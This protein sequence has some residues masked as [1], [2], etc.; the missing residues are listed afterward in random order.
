[1]S[2][3]PIN[4]VF[5]F[6][7]NHSCFIL[8]E[9]GDFN[10]ENCFSYIFTCPLKIIQCFKLQEVK[11]CLAQ[12]QSALNQG[13]YV[14]GFLSYEAGY[15]FEDVLFKKQEYDFP[16][17]WMGVFKKPIIFTH[18]KN[19]FNSKSIKQY[20]K[21]PLSHSLYTIKN[22]G[23]NV[24]K[25]EYLNNLGKIKALLK[26]GDSY[27]VNYTM[28]YKFDFQGS[29]F[30]LY[31]DLRANQAVNYSA[32][33]YTDNFKVLCFS[34]ELFFR[35]SNQQII[36]RPMKGT[37]KRGKNFAED[38]QIKKFLSSDVKNK[39]ENLMIVDLLR[40][41]LGKISEIGSVKTSDLF[42]IEKYKTLFQMTSQISGRLNPEQGT[43]DIFLKLFPCGSIT[44]APKIRTMQIIRA[45]EKEPRNIYTGAI[46]FIS[47]DQTG[48]FNVAIRTVLLRDGRGELG[49][50]GGITIGSNSNL[51]YAECKLKAEFFMRAIAKY[52][53]KNSSVERK[54]DSDFYLFES[55]RWASVSGFFLLDLHLERLKKSAD[56]FHIPYNHQ[57]ILDS[58]NREVEKL[59][60]GYVYKLKLI[61][62]KNCKPKVN[63]V[64]VSA[65]KS[66]LP[67]KIVVSDICVNEHNEFFFH[68]T[69]K[70]GFYEQ[71]ARKYR[72]LGFVEVIFRNKK[73]QITEGAISN[74]FI[75]KS[76]VF[77][78]PP[79]RAGILPGVFRTYFM[80]KNNLRVLE[81]QL[82]LKD[83]FSADEIYIANSVRG[84]IRVY[85][86]SAIN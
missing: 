58:L 78:T 17:F 59:N 82:Y 48:V 2:E 53:D 54:Q 8:L 85:L 76:G 26:A 9:S 16:L 29:Q 81:K 1:M 65:L 11:S 84:L 15:A 70:R 31:Q 12:A 36:T 34:P 73:K 52:S 64:I 33:I 23:L 5:K 40:N 4:N 20:C 75:K 83:L 22:L 55:M 71:Q 18:Y 67:F 13:Y 28:K 44:G 80:R 38:E 77:Y 14:C 24:R 7:E 50:G 61:L 86:N 63:I 47:P 46:G 43:L 27:Q 79:V 57:L 45:M 3:F 42:K 30:A 21:Q 41:D 74:I 66:N 25:K 6:L 56:F 32:F 69:S 60:A 37:A 10:Q 72:E 51:E 68:K 19:K 39:A 62:S 35:V 49:V